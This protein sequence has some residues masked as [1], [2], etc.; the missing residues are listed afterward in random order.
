MAT[1]PKRLPVC[2]VLAFVSALATWRLF[3]WIINPPAFLK[4]TTGHKFYLSEMSM[5]YCGFSAF[6]F[7]VIALARRERF[8]A[9]AVSARSLFSP[10]WDCFWGQ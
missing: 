4:D 8:P 2:A 3:L 10:S 5:Y 7:A 1:P 9:L 6:V